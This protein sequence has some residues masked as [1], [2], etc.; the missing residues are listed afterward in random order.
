V[1][2]ES[3][4]EK[5]PTQKDTLFA[6]GEGGAGSFVFDENV[7]RVFP[8][9]ISRSVPGYGLMVPMIGLLARRYARPGSNVYDLGCSL[10]ATT[11]AICQAAR[12]R[13]IS[14]IAVDNSSA[15]VEQCRI[16]LRQHG[17]RLPV[18][19]RQED[20]R[21][22]G[23]ENASVVALNLTLQF[24]DPRDRAGLLGRI[25]A[26]TN[27]GG[28][29][30]LTEK[31]RFDDPE[32]QRD[33]DE[34]HQDFKRAQ[35]YSELEIARKRTALE[36]V[37]QPDTAARHAERLLEAGYRRV[38]RWFQCFSFQSFVAFR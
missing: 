1:G 18:E 16:N 7:V 9:M 27:P 6:A 14:I 38:E 21:G 19:L 23:F 5:R 28:I 15:M 24:I 17:V 32:S 4:L 12:S 29:L 35:G 36:S 31:V 20:I 10:G 3:V 25:A 37:L 13:E 33:Q 22:T 8:D 34:W 11:L 2:Q 30:V 26:G